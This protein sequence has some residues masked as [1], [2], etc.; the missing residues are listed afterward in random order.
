MAEEPAGNLM[1]LARPELGQLTYC[2]NIHAGETWPEV[3]ASLQTHMPEIKAAVSPRAAFGVGLRLGAA[4]AEELQYDAAF[5]E[6]ARL[7]RENDCYVFTINGFPYGVFHGEPVKE[8]VYAPDWSTEDRLIYTNRLADIL[9]RLVPDG[10]DGTVS[11]VPGTFKAW[12][13]GRIDAITGNLIRHAAHLV[14]LERN[15]GRNI[16]LTLEPEPCCFLETIAESVAYFRDHLFS[17]DAAE[18]LAGMTGLGSEDASVALRRHLGLC[19]DVCHAAVEFEDPAASIA[20]LKDSGIGIGKLQLSSALRIANVSDASI[21]HLRPFDEQVYLH[22]V[23]QRAGD[24]LTRFK[25][26]PDALEKAAEAIGSEWRVHFHVPVFLPELKDFGTT[27][28]FL[29]EVLAIQRATPIS[30]HLEVET[31]TWD[32][33][34]DRYRTAG[35]SAAIARELNWVKS[36][37]GQ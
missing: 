11:T 28:D 21:D 1:Q 37:L 12:M 15:T 16:M 30:G 17:N 26:L 20:A 14:E 4:A 36:E 19:Y 9:A 32:V 34:P 8:N 3:L 33:L 25:D 29:R 31:Y 24:R 27:Q 18:R 35:L 2:T 22:Q 6:L 13:N 5:D 10:M 7:L 23:V